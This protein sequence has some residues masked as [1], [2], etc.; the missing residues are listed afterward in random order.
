MNVFYSENVFITCDAI[1]SSI[2]MFCQVSRNKRKQKTFEHYYISLYSAVTG[3]EGL[4]PR[5]QQAWGSPGPP[6]LERQ[7]G[8][9]DIS[10]NCSRY[11]NELVHAFPMFVQYHELIHEVSRNPRNTF[12]LFNSAG[13]HCPLGSCNPN[14]DSTFLLRYIILSGIYRT[15]K[16][17]SW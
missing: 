12:F 2:A 14:K 4:M 10:R 9:R 15:T 7:R 3:I 13:P 5:G 6:L 8:F 17:Y 1:S 11:S 16:N